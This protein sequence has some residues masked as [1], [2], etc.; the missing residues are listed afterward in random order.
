MASHT[1]IH[2]AK[3]ANRAKKMGRK[4]KRKLAKKS[5]LSYEEL[6]EGMAPPADSTKTTAK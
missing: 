1:K 6:F 3:R 2:Q 4:R 5:T